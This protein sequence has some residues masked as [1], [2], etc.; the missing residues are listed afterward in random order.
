MCSLSI[1]LW[2]SCNAVIIGKYENGVIDNLNVSFLSE[3]FVN[4]SFAG[5]CE[6]RS[7]HR[8]RICV[9]EP[10]FLA[11]LIGHCF[12]LPVHFFLSQNSSVNNI[13]VFYVFIIK[14]FC[15]YLKNRFNL[16]GVSF[17]CFYLR[18]V[19]KCR[20]ININYEKTLLA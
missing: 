14:R 1:Q 9:R 10:V 3:C 18:I 12:I 19:S 2:R 8:L 4:M 20:P 11:N 7:T 17:Y 5:I 6:T 15:Q 13:V 16:L